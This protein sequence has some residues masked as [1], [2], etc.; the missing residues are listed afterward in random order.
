MQVVPCIAY[1]TTYYRRKDQ[2][3]L[4]QSTAHETMDI[5]YLNDDAASDL[6][7]TLTSSNSRNSL[8]SGRV[9]STANL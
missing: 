8:M 7:R 6:N 1:Y 4:N 5:D 2:F 3:I 9:D